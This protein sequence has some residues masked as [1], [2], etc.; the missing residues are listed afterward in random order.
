MHQKIFLCFCHA[1]ILAPTK[2]FFNTAELSTGLS[3]EKFAGVCYTARSERSPKEERSKRRAVIKTDRVPEY[4]IRTQ[5]TE[6][7]KGFAII[8]LCAAAQVASKKK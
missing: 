2:P 1:F 7:G 4:K 3:T 5:K 6:K 8:G